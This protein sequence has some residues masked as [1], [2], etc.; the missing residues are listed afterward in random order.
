MTKSVLIVD[1]SK[2]MRSYIANIIDNEIFTVVGE[3]SN[4][5]EAL[6]Q[7]L[8][9]HPDLVIMD[10][11]MPIMTGIQALREIMGYDPKA[12]VIICSSLGSKQLIIDALMYGAKDF[13]LKP[14]F[15]QINDK[16]EQVLSLIDEAH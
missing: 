14:Y 15:D 5:L 3:A 8:T 1:D 16:L 7:Y 6:N 11:T 9:L 12:N 2:F 10:I 4:G 13:V